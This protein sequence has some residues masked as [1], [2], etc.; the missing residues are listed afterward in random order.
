MSGHELAVRWTP[1]EAAAVAV[2]V[3]KLLVG[4]GRPADDEHMDVYLE[5]LEGL[6]A[7]H[8][9]DGLRRLRLEPRAFAPSPGE[10]RDA[11]LSPAPGPARLEK[12]KAC[13]YHLAACICEAQRE[14][15]EDRGDAV[16]GL[17]DWLAGS[18]REEDY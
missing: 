10:A 15:V 5:A 6:P 12:C 3:R 16:R 17:I 9:I 13:R 4:F 8:V 7:A 14:A 18:T 11:A 2:E 1:S